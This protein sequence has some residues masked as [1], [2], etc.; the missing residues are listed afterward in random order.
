MKCLLLRTDNVRGQIFEHIFASNGGYL[1]IYLFIYL[2][3]HLFIYLFIYI[4]SIS[5]QESILSII[6]E[7][8]QFNTDIHPDIPQFLQGN[9][10][11][12]DVCEIFN[13]L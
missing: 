13:G 8:K 9:I 2:F 7:V 11:S 10:Q 5:S 4:F 1:L 3:I 6:Y 12:F